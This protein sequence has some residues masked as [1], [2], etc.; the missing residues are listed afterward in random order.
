MI[1]NA[2]TTT[3]VPLSHQNNKLNV[4][5][6]LVERTCKMFRAGMPI[7]GLLVEHQMLPKMARSEAGG[8]GV[9]TML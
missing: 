2:T 7:P 3:E 9:K 1:Y 8:G 6:R 5:E 4:V